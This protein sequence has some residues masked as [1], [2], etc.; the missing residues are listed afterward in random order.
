MRKLILIL[1]FIIRL[2]NAQ[3]FEI[4]AFGGSGISNTYGTRFPSIG[5][6]IEPSFNA[7]IAGQYNTGDMISARIEGA[8][9]KKTN[10]HYIT[11]SPSL[12]LNFS[13][14]VRFY[15]MV[16]PWFGFCMNPGMD[17]HIGDG[18]LH[19]GIGYKQNVFK[20]KLFITIEAK[21]Q[22]GLTNIMTEGNGFNNTHCL[23]ISLGISYKL[24]R[25]S[26]K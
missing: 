26:P 1:F 24:P 14:K 18:G 5:T 9:V 4:S 22:F 23:N 6:N 15:F 16:G 17:K 10:L 13:Q 8:Y 2:C 7:G 3:S 25:H 12:V 21:D 11:I 20:E 19:V